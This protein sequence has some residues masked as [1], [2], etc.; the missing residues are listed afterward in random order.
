MKKA[1]ILILCFF[2]LSIPV[3]NASKID[4]LKTPQEKANYLLQLMK[5]YRVL[6]QL[7]KEDPDLAGCVQLKDGSCV[8]YSDVYDGLVAQYIYY[9]NQK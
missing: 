3:A 5:K 8:P 6:I 7:S 1:L 2:F 9:A 4:E